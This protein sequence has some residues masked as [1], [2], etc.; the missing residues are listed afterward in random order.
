MLQRLIN[1]VKDSAGSAL[2]L[3][4]LAGAAAIALFITIAFLCAAAFVFV[5]EHYGPVEAC[6]AGAALFFVVTLI[7][8]GA[9]MARRR[10]MRRRAERAAKATAAAALADPVMIA[11]GLQIVRAIGVKRLIPIIAVG[12]LALGLMASRSATASE[13]PAEEE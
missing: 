8:A 9:F 3:T 2:R 13:E 10:E 6:L 11:T 5:L 4:S 12:G 1:D 7:A